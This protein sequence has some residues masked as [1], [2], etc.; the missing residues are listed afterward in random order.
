M[1]WK[2]RRR[3]EKEA[4]PKVVVSVWG[5]EFVQFLAAPAVLPRSI[6]KK[7]INATFFLLLWISNLQQTKQKLNFSRWDFEIGVLKILRIATS[8]LSVLK[9]LL[10]ATLQTFT[11]EDFP[12]QYDHNCGLGTHKLVPQCSFPQ[13]DSICGSEVVSK[14]Q[15]APEGGKTNHLLSII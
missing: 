5:A 8:V 2:H 11:G 7:R 14:N 15:A 4:K 9:N 1:G 3:M 10:H 6:W 12:L 13:N